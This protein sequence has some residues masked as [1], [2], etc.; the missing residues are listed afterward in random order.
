MEMFLTLLQSDYVAL[1]AIIAF[2]IL[3]GK[4]SVKGVSFGLSAVIFVAMFYGYLMNALGFEDFAIPGI[5]QKIGLLLFIFTIGMQAGPSFFEAFKSQGSKLIILAT[6]SVVSGGLVTFILGITFDIDFK[7]AVGLL[8]GALTSTPGLAAAIESSQS[9]LASIGYGIAYPFGVIGVIL[10]V[11]LAPKFFGVSVEEAEKK[12]EEEATADTPDLVNKNFIVTNDNVHGKTI[13]ELNIRFMTKANISRVMEPN[14]ESK[15]PMKDTILHKGDLVKAVGTQEALKRVEL[16]LGEPTD[17]KI[18]RS[19]IHEIR[20]FVVSSRNIVG[21]TLGEL[22]LHNNYLATITRVRRAGLDLSPRPSTRL[23]FGDKLLI[24]STKGNIVGLTELFGDSIKIVQTPSFLPVA[25]GIIIGVLLGKL[26][27]PL[28]GGSSFSLGLTG[29]VLMAALGLSRLG[30]TGPVIWHLP[31]N[32]NALLRQ[33]GL[34]LFLTPVGVGA[35]TKLVSTISEYGFQLFGIGALITLIPMLI[36]T[37]VGHVFFKVNFLSLMGAL[38]GGMTSTPGLSAMDNMTESDA[39]QVAY[40]TVYPFALVAIIIV[41]Q[42]IG[43]L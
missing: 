13:G 20:W 24:S 32:A 18:P 33:F 6:L 23:R 1:F 4:I 39:P 8:T 29:G 37:I 41:A 22:D 19:G 21:K 12:Y 26:E 35:G 31:S 25:L 3:L 27:V 28:P 7:I 40:A 30:K 15:P 10:F 34:L 11:K 36:V 42:I 17:Q 9:P 5:I 43:G 2:G 16:L 38:T 14:T